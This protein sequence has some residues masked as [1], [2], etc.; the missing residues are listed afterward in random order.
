MPRAL[1]VCFY[2]RRW[3]KW[4]DMRPR[5]ARQNEAARHTERAHPSAPGAVGIRKLGNLP[6]TERRDRIVCVARE[7][8]VVKKPLSAS[9]AWRSAQ[10]LQ[11]F[12]SCTF[13]AGS[14]SAE[15][16]APV[17]RVDS[18]VGRRSSVSATALGSAMCWNGGAT[19][20]SPCNAP[21]EVHAS[22]ACQQP[23]PQ[24]IPDVR[25]PAATRATHTHANT[26]TRMH[27][28]ARAP[29][30]APQTCPQTTYGRRRRRSVRK[31]VRITRQR[32]CATR[33]LD[34]HR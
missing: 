23:W 34:L 5:E 22:W 19:V 12:G 20:R 7:E 18:L 32:H 25:S 31:P 3:R 13:W 24:P 16:E 9:A 8:P 2:R 28:S 14:P 15:L 1:A 29:A 30:R 4:Q 10:R 26:Y 11:R 33:R 27:K 6:G 17:I 21:L